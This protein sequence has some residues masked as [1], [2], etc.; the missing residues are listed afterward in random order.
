MF[1]QGI[2][3]KP[4]HKST[5]N[6]AA[7]QTFLDLSLLL[8]DL[9]QAKIKHQTWGQIKHQIHPLPW[10][11]HERN[12]IVLYLAIQQSVPVTSPDHSYCTLGSR[13]HEEALVTAFCLSALFKT[14]DFGPWIH[15]IFEPNLNYPVFLFI[16]YYITPVVSAPCH[17]SDWDIQ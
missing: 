13:N 14:N 9:I 16:R 1:Y 15:T 7:A 2:L 3:E 12:G 5:V 4:S 6:E 10:Y 11:E 17:C 8:S